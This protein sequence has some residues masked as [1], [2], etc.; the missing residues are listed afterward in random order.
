MI[1]H[2]SLISCHP[3]GIQ[4]SP[5]NWAR[6]WEDKNMGWGIPQFWPRY[7]F[8]FPGR[9]PASQAYKC[10]WNEGLIAKTLV[11][12][13]RVMLAQG[14]GRGNVPAGGD[15]EGHSTW[16][17]TPSSQNNPWQMALKTKLA[18]LN[19]ESCLQG[20]WLWLTL[21]G[22][23]VFTTFFWKC[24]GHNQRIR[25]ILGCGMMWPG[26]S[27]DQVLAR[28]SPRAHLELETD[29]RLVIKEWH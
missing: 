25:K 18:G 17:M 29:S 9:V 19:S 7:T 6:I 22:H 12:D 26:L 14:S 16:A 1:P 5:G 28:K 4:K 27:G 23:P 15:K 2:R 8:S 11:P 13:T 10:E 21:A 3:W 20:W 24:L